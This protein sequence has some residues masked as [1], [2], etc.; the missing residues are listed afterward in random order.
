MSSPV[1]KTQFHIDGYVGEGGKYMG[2]TGA[3]VK[4]LRGDTGE[5]PAAAVTDYGRYTLKFEASQ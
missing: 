3:A 4:A 2:V 1:P 5:V